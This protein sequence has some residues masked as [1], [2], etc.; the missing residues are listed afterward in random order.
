MPT[1][2]TRLH[3][4]H[5]PPRGYTAA[6]AA[7]GPDYLSF[8]G[9]GYFKGPGIHFSASKHSDDPVFGGGNLGVRRP[10]RF[11]T[12]RLDLSREQAAK[13]ARVIERI[14]IEREQAN[15]DLRRAAAEMADAVDGE[16]FDRERMQAAQERR[17]EAARNTQEVVSR[18]LEEF[19]EFL[20]EDQRETFAAL[21]RSREISF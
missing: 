14:K 19:H 5:W 10:L 21:I 17:I 18:G 7:S 4:A 15:V 13:A 2:Y 3:R 8:K 11:L 9:P 16:T 12:W 6:F 20:D 1:F